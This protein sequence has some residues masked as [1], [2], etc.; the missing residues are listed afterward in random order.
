MSGRLGAFWR[1]GRGEHNTPQPEHNSSTFSALHQALAAQFDTCSWRVAY[2]DMGRLVRRIRIRGAHRAGSGLLAGCD[3]A[4][5]LCSGA[6]GEICDDAEPDPLSNE[7][8]TAALTLRLVCELCQLLEPARFEQV[9]T[10]ATE[11]LAKSSGLDEMAAQK[12]LHDILGQDLPTARVFKA[13]TQNVIFE[14]IYFLREKVIQKEKK[15]LEIGR[16]E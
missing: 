4:A 16:W 6:E 5:G 8:S 14:P 9:Q 13:I 2:K 15:E 10:T 1:R 3:L 11:L 12:L 7:E